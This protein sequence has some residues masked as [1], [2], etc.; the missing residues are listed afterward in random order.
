MSWP[1]AVPHRKHREG[2]VRF[3]EIGDETE[4]AFFHCLHPKE[5][6]APEYV[7]ARRKWY[8]EHREKGYRAKVLILDNG[9]IVGKCHYIP[10]EYSPL[11][12]RDLLVILCL[13]VHMYDQHV[14]DQRGQGYGQN[15]LED[16]EEGA[17]AAG[18]KGIAAWAMDWTWNPVSF[19]EHLGYTRVD[20]EDKVVVVWKPF[21]G[22]AEPPRLLRLANPPPKGTDKVA[23]FVADNGWC[24]GYDKLQIAK[25]AIA[26]LEST[27]AFQEAGPPY[28]GRILH[29]GHVGGVF[30]DGEPYRPYQVIGAS[31]DLRAKILRLHE[32]KCGAQLG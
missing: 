14:G 25:E 18:F 26:S 23:V 3:I 31:E 8:A 10:I 7:L 20:Q 30:L 6:P 12:G 21:A 22:D 13:Y 29:L 17:R 16:V 32:Q 9:Q 1:L 11:V 15:M 28:R 4:A 19:Y 24:N 27:V 2:L 5:A